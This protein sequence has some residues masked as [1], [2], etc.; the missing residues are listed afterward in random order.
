M[1]SQKFA[2]RLPERG[3]RILRFPLT[4]LFIA[5]LFFVS[6]IGFAI[7]LAS[8][9]SNAV[10]SPDDRLGASAI[11]MVLACLFAWAG[12]ALYCLTV[13]GR[14]VHELD[15]RK[16]L[17][18]TVYGLL[19]G[20]GFISLV[21]LVMWLTG[22]YRVAGIRTVAV[23]WP[24]LI[25]SVQAGVVEEILTRG[26]IF[27]IAE[28]AIGT[29]WSV[30][31]SALIFGFMHIWNPNATVFSSVSIALTAGVILALLYVVTRQL[32][33]P[34]G[35]HAGWNFTLG[36][37]YGA[38][39]SGGEPGGILEASFPGP[40]WITGGAFGPEASVI[41]LTV[42]IIFG[43]Y[44]IRRVVRDN[45]HIKPMWRKTI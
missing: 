8:L 44:L 23:L 6:F 33:V 40:E 7:G 1:D 17:R 42:F 20:F 9:L 14:N 10:L 30:V 5:I 34:I 38:P 39:V 18:Q 2:I 19:L 41:T 11:Q 45:S 22:G 35:L 36:G 32:W 13:E 4:R 12:Y 16:G 37:I 3:M 25:M 43:I 26:I 27:R 21:M 24:V 29:W 28:E 31:L 15:P